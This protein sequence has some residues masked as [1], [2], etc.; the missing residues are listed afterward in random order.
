MKKLSSEELSMVVGG[1]KRSF[2]HG[3]QGRGYM[4]VM[5]KH[6]K[7]AFGSSFIHTVISGLKKRH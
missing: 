4:F 6:V 3:W 7:R 5:P 1:S 2:R